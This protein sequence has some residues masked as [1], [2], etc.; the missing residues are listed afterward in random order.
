MSAED[1][2]PSSCS[3][4]DGPSRGGLQS[5]SGSLAVKPFTALPVSGDSPQR[6]GLDVEGIHRH[7]SKGKGKGIV[8]DVECNTPKILKSSV[9]NPTNHFDPDASSSGMDI[10]VNRFGNPNA[11][12]VLGSKINEDFVSPTHKCNPDLTILP[13]DENNAG[14]VDKVLENLPKGNKEAGK[15]NNPW[16]INQYI[17]LNFNEGNVKLSEDGKA[18]ILDESSVAQNA[19]RHEF[20]LVTKVFGKV[21]PSHVVAWELRKQWTRFGQFHFTTLGEGW[22]LC[23]FKSLEALEGVLSGGPWF[24]NYHIVGM[25]RCSTKFS[26]YSMKGLSS[27]I[28][29]RMPHLP[30][31]CWDE[32]NVAFIASRVGVPLMLDENM[33]QWGRREFARVCVRVMLDKPLPLGVWVEGSTGRFFQ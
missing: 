31:H 5:S 10:F 28:W 25:E 1:R 13:L 33:F 24:V 22:Y 14:I 19:K 3:S 21:L 18:V 20:S 8:V 6:L 23:S 9:L 7:K 11:I 26:P 12:P 16:K 17:Q 15:L 29:I 2:R 30:L 4:E 32:N 27:P